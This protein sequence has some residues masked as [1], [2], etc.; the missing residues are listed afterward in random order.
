MEILK[1]KLSEDEANELIKKIVDAVEIDDRIE[2]RGFK[3]EIE[4]LGM[5]IDFKIR[6]YTAWID[7][8][9]PDLPFLV[10]RSVHF[11]F[12]MINEH[13]SLV[14]VASEVDIEE[15]VIKEFEI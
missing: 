13:G 12:E 10:W 14:D 4:F 2:D 15:K 7:A 3:K 11:S 6:F 9:L 8:E 5:T 1:V